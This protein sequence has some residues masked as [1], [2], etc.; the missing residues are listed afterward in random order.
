MPARFRVVAHLQG[1][2]RAPAARVLKAGHARAIRPFQRA[3]RHPAFRD[4]QGQFTQRKIKLPVIFRLQA[5][6]FV[7]QP[8]NLPH[9]FHERRIF[10]HPAP[11]LEYIRDH[12]VHDDGAIDGYKGIRLVWDLFHENK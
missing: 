1:H 7:I 10:F 3:P 9:A 4:A 6:F 5:E 12:R 8:A 2:L 11:A